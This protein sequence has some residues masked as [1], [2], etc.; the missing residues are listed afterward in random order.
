M[1]RIGKQIV[2][3]PSGTEVNLADKKLTVKGPKGTLVREFPGNIT[4]NINN[5]EIT[6]DEAT[7]RLFA[8]IKANFKYFF[9]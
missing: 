9:Y 5:N 4:I 8:W 3:I 1:S 2:I 7:D 6:F